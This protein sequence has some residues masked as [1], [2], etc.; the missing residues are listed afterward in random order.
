MSLL[1]F[2]GMRTI[3]FLLLLIPNI[4]LSQCVGV[5]SATL[6]PLPTNG[7]YEPGTVVTMCYTM[8]GWNGTNFG[9]NWIEGFSINLGPGW[10]SHTPIS[11]PDDCGGAVPPQQW[12]WSESETN[13]NGTL[14]VGPG[15]FYE[16]PTGPIDGNAGNDWG[17]F[18]IDCQWTFCVQLIASDVCDPLS[19]LIE[20]TAYADGSMGSWGT[21]SCF[22][23]PYQVFNGTIAGGNVN[24]SLIGVDMDTVCVGLH[25]TY[26]VVN[27]PGS[28]Y[29]WTLSNGGILTEDGTN[30]AFV[31]WGGVPGNYVVSVQETTV[32]GCIGEI[33][34]TTITVVDTLITF[35]QDNIGMCLEGTV[36][37]SA[38]PSGGFWAG[39]NLVGN[40]FTGYNS[41]TYYPLYFVNIYGCPVV[42]SVEVYVRP[43]FM[44]P[45]IFAQSNFI[46][47]CDDPYNQTYL[48]PDS[49]G[50]EYTW[51][52]DG[53][54][55]PD[56][57]FELNVLWSDTTMDHTITVYGTDT[58]G[59]E[60]EL[61][62]ITIRTNTC[63]R[64]YVP[65]SFTPNNDGFNDA[66]KIAGMSVYEPDMK[67]YNRDGMMVYNI[68]S[69]S[70]TWN[71]NDG[72]GYYCQ[73]GVYNWIMTYKD[74]KNIGHVEKG[75]VILIR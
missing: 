29:D 62:A 64:L 25:Q 44:A 41:G 2:I 46:D 36:L 39:E 50:I 70:Q 40:V 1:I 73:T 67:I 37:L 56:T 57:D 55:Q 35:G 61:N 71:G 4:I 13:N 33:V 54:L 11:G 27:T 51:H 20:V 8:N 60:S 24:T 72:S 34:D 23:G 45:E 47:F 12:L 17:D 19:L 31:D 68:K 65:N 66:F 53:V 63:Y 10:V 75:Q 43:K 49:V 3:L 14:T 48:A 18:G 16:G 7:T 28:T 69:L 6:S 30:I 42:D 21:E 5:Q 38:S 59:C 52:V 15:Y 22:D 26:S 74:D 9:S 32:D 58:L